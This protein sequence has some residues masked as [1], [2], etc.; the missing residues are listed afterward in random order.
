MPFHELKTRMPLVEIARCQHISAV[1]SSVWPHLSFSLGEQ[2]DEASLIGAA[3]GLKANLVFSMRCL[4]LVVLLRPPA[5]SLPYMLSAG[6]KPGITN[7]KQMSSSVTPVI[8]KPPR[9]ITK[10]WQAA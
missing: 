8:A 5:A 7:V 10:G 9:S 3:D 4:R 6:K 2:V 1:P